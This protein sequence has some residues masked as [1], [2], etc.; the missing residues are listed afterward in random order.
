MNVTKARQIRSA[1]EAEYLADHCLRYASYVDQEG[2]ALSL[3]TTRGAFEAGLDG[4]IDPRV[5]QRVLMG[6]NEDGSSRVQRQS[7]KGKRQRLGV[8]HCIS[9]SKEQSALCIYDRELPVDF[10]HTVGAGMREVERR[11]MTRRGAGTVCFESIQSTIGGATIHE[12]S[13]AGDFQLHAHATWEPGCKRDDAT[14]GVVTGLFE[15]TGFLRDFVNA[16]MAAK[17][18]AKKYEVVPLSNGL[19]FTVKG[20]KGVAE[21]LVEDH[22]KRSK[23]INAEVKRLGDESPAAKATAALTTRPKQPTETQEERHARWR[24]EAEAHGFTEAAWLSIRSH[25]LPRALTEGELTNLAMNALRKLE[26]SRVFTA[27]DLDR[28]VLRAG[29]GSG[30][31]AHSLLEAAGRALELSRACE[32]G[33][34]RRGTRYFATRERLAEETRLMA[35]AQEL[36]DSTCL[37]ASERE[38]ARATK[39]FERKH[40]VTL[41]AEQ[42][43]AVH[44]ITGTQCGLACVDG[45]AGTGKSSMAG[46]AAAIWK[47]ELG[48]TVVGCATTAIA[49]RGIEQAARVKGYTLER[50]L[51]ELRNPDEKHEDIRQRISFRSEA[52]A[53][54]YLRKALDPKRQLR[55][56]VVLVD[57]SSM[58][59]P[60]RLCDLF[61]RAKEYGFKIV[62]LGD[63]EQLKP[64]GSY[65]G[66]FEALCDRFGA[67]RLKEVTRQHAPWE[68]TA[69]GQVR[70][71]ELAE[72]LKAFSEKRRIREAPGHR[73]AMEEL[74]RDWRALGCPLDSLIL[75]HTRKAALELNALAQQA[76]LAQGG[77]SGHAIRFGD[78]VLYRGD[79]VRFTRNDTRLGVVNGERGRVVRGLPG[80]VIIATEKRFVIIPIRAATK[81]VSLGYA[82][83]THAAQGATTGL[84]FVFVEGPIRDEAL[85]YVQLSRAKDATFLYV[86]S[87]VA[88]RG[89]LALVRGSQE[90]KRQAL[91]AARR[92]DPHGEAAIRRDIARE[93]ERG[94]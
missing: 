77:L 37:P 36:R 13:R 69:V 50:L 9:L 4:P 85:A 35:L 41:T 54:A 24:T 73:A 38:I 89:L 68:R 46:A 25:T 84:A 10:L 59:G 91:L 49:A 92:L 28:A 7:H 11:L 22:S 64:I 58:V 44:A 79:I 74:I 19:G 65:P 21:S 17:L 61:K 30:A 23:D 56:D 86:D 33:I 75:T 60:G 70:E 31:R 78:G 90:S 32:L 16:D 15:Q 39:R 72:A 48:L 67:A 82:S 45:A 43:S 87:N 80:A 53:N 76:R 40:G 2:H 83:T 20:V 51:Y 34:D 29:I 71:G 42:R 5:H 88:D 63:S 94:L 81:S 66:T 26:A 62:L 27:N 52:Q 55:P 93:Q 1:R 8:E 14:T 57:E 6:L 12:S 18:Q 3:W 47:K